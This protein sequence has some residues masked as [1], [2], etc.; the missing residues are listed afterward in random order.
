V[1]LRPKRKMNSSSLRGGLSALLPR[2]RSPQCLVAPCIVQSIE[3]E[4]SEDGNFWTWAVWLRWRTSNEALWAT[5]R[6]SAASAAATSAVC[7]CTL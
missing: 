2:L 5:T 1:G 4:R 3:A 6:T 7:T